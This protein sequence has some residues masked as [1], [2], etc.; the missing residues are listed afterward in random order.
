MHPTT[1]QHSNPRANQSQVGTQ[2]P[3]V[4]RYAMGVTQRVVCP[5]A[6]AN[7]TGVQR[8]NTETDARAVRPYKQHPSH[9]VIFHTVSMEPMT[10]TSSMV[11]MNS[12]KSMVGT[13][14]PCVRRSA[15]HGTQR[16]ALRRIP[17]N[18]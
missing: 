9:T 12:M 4:R 5:S 3:C 15:I 16:V 13:Q 8:G 11:S 1:T 14:G 2:G 7:P 18:T 17:N 10:S 6:H